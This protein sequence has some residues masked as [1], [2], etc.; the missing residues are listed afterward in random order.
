M[1]CLVCVVILAACSQPAV[2]SNRPPDAAGAAG[3]DAAIRIDAAPPL[4]TLAPT[5]GTYRQACDGSGGVALDFDH[6]LSFADDDQV[7]RVYTRGADGGPTQTLD[8]NSGIG[9]AAGDEADLED[10]ARVGNRIYVITSHGRTKDGVK[11]TSRYRYF[12]LDIAGT[13]F[14]AVGSANHLL[15]DL[16]VAANWDTPNP[17]IIASLTSASQLGQT[18]VPTLAPED[19]GTN[20]EGLAWANGKLLIGFRNPQA[21]SH[22]LVVT[23]TNPDAVLTAG[24]TAHFGEA[25]ELDFGGLGIRSMTW[26]PLLGAVL[27]IAGPH[28]SNGGFKLYKWSGTAQGAPVLIQDLATTATSHPE[29]VIAYPDTKDVQIVYDAGDA[30]IGNTT[31]K[32]AALADRQF[33]DAIIHL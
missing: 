7:I 30:T 28:D 24:A 6:F 23:L 8:I 10:A 12:A 19:Q 22:A 33:T 26:S 3:E 27:V 25:I 15:Q 20:I 16:L 1:R 13:T 2:D 18:T 32:K 21:S 31:C 29:S 4:K 14:N 9:L 17:A 11:Q 5:P